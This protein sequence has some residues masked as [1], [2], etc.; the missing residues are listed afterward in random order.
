MALALF[1]WGNSTATLLKRRYHSDTERS[2]PKHSGSGEWSEA[3]PSIAEIFPYEEQVPRRQSAP[4]LMR[5]NDML[6]YCLYA[7]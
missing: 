5:G 7:I 3:C 2:C 1:V 4:Q 6:Y